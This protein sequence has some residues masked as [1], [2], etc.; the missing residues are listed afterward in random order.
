M[1]IC[2]L[3]FSFP[4]RPFAC[5]FRLLTR[6]PESTENSMFRTSTSSLLPGSGSHTTPDYNYETVA[7]VEC[8]PYATS[9]SAIRVSHSPLRQGDI[10]VQLCPFYRCESR[11]SVIHLCFNRIYPKPS[12]CTLSLL[13]KASSVLSPCQEATISRIHSGIKEVGRR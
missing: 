7:S 12:C 5:Q 4:G 8:V 13:S 11:P 10:S 3:P 2:S 9:S 1:W 6:Q